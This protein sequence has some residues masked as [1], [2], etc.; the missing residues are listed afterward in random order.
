MKTINLQLEDSEHK[1]LRKKKG[2]HTW[3]YAL[4][5]GCEVLG[6]EKESY[7]KKEIGD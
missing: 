6:D 2:A 1:I 3:K 7:E 5:R 4:L